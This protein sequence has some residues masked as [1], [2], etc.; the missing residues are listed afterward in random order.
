[1]VRLGYQGRATPL[2]THV[3]PGNKLWV[4]QALAPPARSLARA[5][6]MLAGAGFSWNAAGT[7]LDRAGT[8]VEFTLITNAGNAARVKLAAIAE[9]DLRQLGMRARLVPLENRA[10]LD[11]VF[12]T[13]DYDAAVMALASGDVDPNSEMNVWLSGGATHLWRLRGARWRT[14]RGRS[15]T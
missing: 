5:R 13:H 8:P 10:L 11:R 14:G 9:D 1:M 7:L 12:E 3:T 2:G 15:T 6:E 4:N